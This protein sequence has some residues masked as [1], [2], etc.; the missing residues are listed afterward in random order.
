MRAALQWPFYPY[1]LTL[2]S[3]WISNH[4]PSEMRDQITY[5]FPNFKGCTVEICEWMN[6]CIPHCN[7]CNY[8]S[9]IWLK[10]IFDHI[11]CYQLI[12]LRT[13]PRDVFWNDAQ[14]VSHGTIHKRRHVLSV[15]IHCATRLQNVVKTC[16]LHLWKTPYHWWGV[17]N[18]REIAPPGNL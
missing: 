10:L 16:T 3:T 15:Y 1:W 18:Q 2:I 9:I 17:S 6:Y 4:M 12:F 11:L 14:L 13:F 7:L 8:I 5:P